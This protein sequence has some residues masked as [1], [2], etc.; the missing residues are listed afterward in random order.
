VPA[1]PVANRTVV[2]RRTH[3]APR[4]GGTQENQRDRDRGPRPQDRRPGRGEV[5]TAKIRSSTLRGG[6]FPARGGSS[7]LRGEPFP[8]RGGNSTLR[9]GPFPDRE[10][11]STRRGGPFP[12]REGSSMLR[13]GPFP[14]RGGSSALRGEPF[15]AREGLSIAGGELSA[16]RGTFRHSLRDGPPA[17]PQL[18][19]DEVQ[20]CHRIARSGYHRVHNSLSVGQDSTG[21]A[22]F[23]SRGDTVVLV[24]Y[25]I[26]AT[27]GPC[28]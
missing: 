13:G 11:S 22:S 9:G 17:Q 20:G 18:N 27:S 2:R 15:I 24:N 12:D 19:L 16:P 1:G 7:T 5:S 3:G 8:D 26:Q 21:R 14:A 28:D 23:V 25:W 10:G 6:L 4:G